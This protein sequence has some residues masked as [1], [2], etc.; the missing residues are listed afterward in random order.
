MSGIY[1]NG[2]NNIFLYDDHIQGAEAQSGGIVIIYGRNNTVDFVASKYNSYS[3][4][5]ISNSRGNRISNSILIGNPSAD[6]SCLAN[7]SF[8]FSNAFENTTCYANIGCNFAYC[9][10]TNIQSSISS[11]TLPYSIDEC[12]SES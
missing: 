7:S 10:Q 11:I 1:L 9:S 4:L 2:S 6:I 5:N 12:G 3:G 8:R